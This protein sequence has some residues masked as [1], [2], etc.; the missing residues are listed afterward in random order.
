VTVATGLACA[1]VLLLIVTAVGIFKSKT[2]WT[3]A[4]VRFLV[5]TVFVVA[6]LINVGLPLLNG[7][8]S[9]ILA[10]LYAGLFSYLFWLRSATNRALTGSPPPPDVIEVET[11][12]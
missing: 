6:C 1:D 11:D 4:R 9:N 5:W 12:L 3:S 8:V 10:I 7:R 2:A